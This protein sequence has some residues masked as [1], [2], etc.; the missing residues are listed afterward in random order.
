MIID[1]HLDIAYNAL[2]FG[3]D[4]T[5]SAAETRRREGPRDLDIATV[6]LPDALK[7]GLGLVFGTLFV[8]P[9]ADALHSPIVYHTPEEA[10]QQALDQLAYYHGLS[11]R[12]DVVMVE[13]QADMAALL[14]ARARGQQLQGVVVLMEGADPVLAPSQAAEWQARG[15]RIIGPAWKA[16]RY[17]GGTGQPGPLTPL[18][19]ELMGELRAAGLTLDVSHMAE[20]SFWD[21]MGLF[22]GPVIA[23]HSNC[24]ALVPN[25]RADRHLSDEMIRE[26]VGRGAVIGTVLYNRFLVEGWTQE[27]GKRAVGLDA[28][29]AHIDHVCQIAGDAL[30]VGIGSDSDGGFGT[31]ATPREIDTI[32]DLP[33]IGEALLARGYS[34]ADVDAVMG[35]NWQRKLGEILPA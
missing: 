25:S 14:A 20:Q 33:K 1:A 2:N 31:E 12:H 32:A 27:Q 22:D 15:V 21:A 4:Y 10:H 17:C 8:S 23:S 3:R 6:G 9:A 13:R 30:H 16:T 35:G 18:G 24:R 5:L 19:R 11:A 29:V 34:Q 7:A 28:V 26:L